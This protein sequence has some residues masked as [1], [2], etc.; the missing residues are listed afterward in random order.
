MKRPFGFDPS[1]GI[2]E[3]FL[4]NEGE[5]GFAVKQSQ[6]AEQIVRFNKAMQQCPELR[7]QAMKEDSLVHFARVPLTVL[8]EW[9][10]RYGIDWNRKEDLPKIEKLLNSNEYRDLRSCPK[11]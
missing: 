4:K 5:K 10:I 8:L 11:I 9:K 1:S 3:E 6:D 7:Q 2:R